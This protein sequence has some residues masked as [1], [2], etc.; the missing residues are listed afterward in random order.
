EYITK[1]ISKPNP[2]Y[3]Q[4]PDYLA[5]VRRHE[6]LGGRLTAIHRLRTTSR[7]LESILGPA[8]FK[9]LQDMWAQDRKRCRW[10]V[11]FPIVESYEIV[12]KPFA[13]EVFARSDYASLYQRPSALLREL[14]DVQ[15][16]AIGV[17]DLNPVDA[18][19]AWI[20][21]EDEFTMAKASQI[22]PLTRGTID[23]DLS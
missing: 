9:Q 12:G 10:S 3:E 2:G 11:A 19:N 13:D 15:Q 16:R 23:E 20:G 6:E 17:L 8:E 14:N 22:D 18:H 7:R 4:H 21:I 1:G 5:E